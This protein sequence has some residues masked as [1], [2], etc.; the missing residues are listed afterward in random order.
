MNKQ[1]I[2]DLF[3]QLADLSTEQAP[4]FE[5]LVPFSME[6]LKKRLSQEPK[7]END[8]QLTEYAC[9]CFCFYQYCLLLSCKTPQQIQMLNLSVKN[10]VAHLLQTA[11]QMKEEAILSIRHL[12]K[13][14]NFYFG[15]V[16]T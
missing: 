7:T 12:C 2:F 5:Y 9:S 10:D 3:C 11:R 4:K 1:R 8:I 15:G 6:Q 14:N 16:A 13:D